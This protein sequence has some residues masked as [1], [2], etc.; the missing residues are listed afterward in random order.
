MGRPQEQGQLGILE[1]NVMDFDVNHL[2]LDNL[3]MSLAAPYHAMHM[4][5]RA[6]ERVCT[7][8]ARED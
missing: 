8:M 7:V 2:E 4:E 1:P 3:G 6:I 5:V